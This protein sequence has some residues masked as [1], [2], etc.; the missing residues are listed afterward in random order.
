[1]FKLTVAHVDDRRPVFDLVNNLMGK[2]F[3]DKGYISQ[4]LLQ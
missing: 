4:R 3:V 1:V 2:L